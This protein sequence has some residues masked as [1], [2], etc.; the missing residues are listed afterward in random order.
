MI[1]K[2]N[3][4]QDTTKLKTLEIIRQSLDRE[5][6]WTFDEVELMAKKVKNE[7]KITK[8]ELENLFTQDF[9]RVDEGKTALEQVFKYSYVNKTSYDEIKE[10]IVS[11]SGVKWRKN[12]FFLTINDSIREG[13]EYV[14]IEYITITQE[15]ENISYEIKAG[16][17]N[18]IKA[19]EEKLKVYSPTSYMN[20]PRLTEHRE[21][22]F[23][24]AN[25]F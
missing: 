7:H 4:Q 9:L 2:N 15:V 23:K 8:E 1:T 3:L 14:R 21:K 11:R 17:M 12:R 24:E 6:F 22:R 5:L 13:I 19:L 25:L 10:Y 16:I 18:E 20:D